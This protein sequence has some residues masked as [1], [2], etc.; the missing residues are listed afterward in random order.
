VHPLVATAVRDS[1]SPL[2][3]GQLHRR[4]ASLLTR[5]GASEEQIAMHLL[6]APPEDDP[7]AVQTLRT[8]ARHAMAAGAAASAVRML[9][10]A[11][12]EQPDAAAD[13]EL[14][15]ELAEAA[16]KA[17]TGAALAHLDY[18]LRVT[19]DNEVRARL[20]LAQARAR[21]AEGAYREAGEVVAAAL[22]GCPDDASL[23]EQL[24]S[25][26]IASAF[27]VPEL[28]GEAEAVAQAFLGRIDQAPTVAQLDTLAHLTIHGGLRG[29]TRAE[30]VQ[31][32]QLAWSDGALIDVQSLDGLSWPLLSG[33]LLYAGELEFCLEVCDAAM[34]AA[35]RDG[36]PAAFTAASYCRAWPLY[37]LGRIADAAVDAQVGLDAQPDGWRMYLR[38]A[39]AAIALCHI[40]RGALDHAETALSIIDVPDVR[41]CIHVPSLLE[42]RAQL[43]LAQHR[44]DEALADA[45]RAGAELEDTLQVRHPGAV[46]WQST[47][48]F[49]KLA[50]GDARGAQTLSAAELETAL[51]LD[52]PRLIV[53]NLRLLGLAEGG[54]A[55]LDL[56][57]DAVARGEGS[58]SLEYLCALVDYGGA[59]RRGNRRAA[60]R[61]PLRLALEAAH[62]GG[63][64]VL[65]ERA[66]VELAA[67]GGR[68]RRIMLSGLESLTPSE[69]R[70]AEIAGQGLTTRQMAEALFV[71]TKTVE[72][73]LGNIYRK[74]DI[75]SRAELA[76][77]LREQE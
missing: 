28:A 20:S 35:R 22:R 47:A 59:L 38:T 66:Q 40:Q 53:R 4:A 58:G 31:I 19:E 18:A 64:T 41:E 9:E 49:A 69:R 32:G 1:I 24:R 43:R 34:E 33:A 6:R 73:H 44:P 60:A 57:Q 77:I 50:L 13:P 51:A 2:L 67:A 39:Y 8:A 76:A 16:A 68:A 55:G 42:A 48:A 10:R 71:T 15:A 26:L 37:E 5:E 62:R 12:A 11:V 14:V 46:P 70:V 74:L 25:V 30:V 61:E 36:S 65:V 56:L 54:Q 7:L 29:A 27:F 3:R 45:L 75:K 17:G 72:F 63:A 23:T 21:Y 52:V